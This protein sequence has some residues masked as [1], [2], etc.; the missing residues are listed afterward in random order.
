MGSSHHQDESWMD[1]EFSNLAQ[2]IEEMGKEL[3]HLK[4]HYKVEDRFNE[5]IKECADTKNMVDKNGFGNKD[6]KSDR[7]GYGENGFLEKKD[8]LV[9]SSGGPFSSEENS[10][11]SQGTSLFDTDSNSS[12]SIT[13]GTPN[14]IENKKVRLVLKLKRIS[15]KYFLVDK[16]P[17][18]DTN[19]KKLFLNYEAERYCFQV[20]VN[21]LPKVYRCKVCPKIYNKI[22][23][24]VFH[25]RTHSKLPEG[26]N[27]GDFARRFSNHAAPIEPYIP[28]AHNKLTE[29]LVPHPKDY[30]GYINIAAGLPYLKTASTIT[31]KDDTFFV[32]ELIGE[33]GFAKV[34]G[35]L[36]SLN[37]Y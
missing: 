20:Y 26:Y 19:L 16:L 9:K 13:N 22:T 34:R 23:S 37:Q 27:A 29:N 32:G 14:G 36:T 2:K 1:E 10:M 15:R 12:F 6:E 35:A 17:I 21:D 24:L 33:G 3:D 5:I 25:K 18:K 4:D 28:A 31:F 30:P 8:I 11:A 7:S